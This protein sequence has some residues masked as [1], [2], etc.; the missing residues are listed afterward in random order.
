VHVNG[1][2]AAMNCGCIVQLGVL[3]SWRSLGFGFLS[4]ATVTGE[5]REQN[6]D[7]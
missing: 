4:H 6:Y 7:P 1:D 3:F 5:Q 2:G